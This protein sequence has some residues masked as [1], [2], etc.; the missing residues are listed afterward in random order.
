MTQPQ[1]AALLAALENEYW[2]L[3]D[4]VEQLELIRRTLVPGP[5]T[6]W[7]G[8]ARH[9]Y[10]SAI[11]GLTTTVEAGL[12]ALRS[13]RDRVGYAVNQVVSRVG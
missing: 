8:T 5:A 2:Q 11:A 13:A 3:N 9:A 7:K 6:F 10:D 1:D 12:A 4:A